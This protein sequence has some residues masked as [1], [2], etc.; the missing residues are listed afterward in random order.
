MVN[1]ISFS[2]SE[3]E[4]NICD[5][6]QTFAVSVSAFIAALSLVVTAITIVYAYREY[7][8]S[9][10]DKRSE[11]F[12]KYNQRYEENEHIQRIVKYCTIEG[13]NN[14]P[15]VYDKELFLRFHEE[16]ERMI[17]A[18]YISEDDVCEFFAYYFVLLWNDDKHFFWD[19]EMLYPFDNLK[20]A[21]N[22][23]EWRT[24]KSLYNRIRTNH[25][26]P[27]TSNHKFPNNNTLNR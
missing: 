11:V 22:S 13:E 20:D 10:K 23:V 24:L 8:R 21:Q 18:D 25:N 27:D 5:I 6:I 14:P 17:K 16:L 19:Q 15:T 2:L 4:M 7:K 12:M 26:T 1:K 3:N 9:L